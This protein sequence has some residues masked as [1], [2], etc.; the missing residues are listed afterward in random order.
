M[1][2]VGRSRS[3]LPLPLTSSQPAGHVQGTLARR[4]TLRLHHRSCPR[5]QQRRDSGPLWLSSK[6]RQAY[7]KAPATVR[8]P[9]PSLRTDVLGQARGGGFRLA[10]HRLYYGARS[11]DKPAATGR[12]LGHCDRVHTTPATTPDRVVVQDS[13]YTTSERR[14]RCGLA[15]PVGPLALSRS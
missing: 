4:P 11:S 14:Q 8:D 1:P 3:P 13:P 6:A 15:P 10:I 5:S 9:G 7:A 12:T 2:H